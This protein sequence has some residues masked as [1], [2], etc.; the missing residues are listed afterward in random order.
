MYDTPKFSLAGDQAIVMA[1]GD[2]ISPEINRQV[3][4]MVQAIQNAKVPGV[5]EL[6]PTYRSLLIYY[7]PMKTSVA[8]LQDTL[9]KLSSDIENLQLR[10]PNV[11]QIPVLYGG[12]HGP[13]LEFVAKHAGVPEQEVIDVHSSATYLVYAMG[14]S[15]GF[16]Y[17]G[18]LP[19]ALSTPR[20]TSPRISIPAGSVGIA[21]NQTGIYPVA[22]PGG[23]QLIGR[24]PLNLFDPNFEPPTLL[25]AGDYVRFS[26][27]R[28]PQE[29]QDIAD[30]IKKGEYEVAI[31]QVE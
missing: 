19:E 2:G 3:H 13:D 10:R 16:P 17:L 11:V 14:F 12:E 29:Y 31:E 28:T 15:P 23:W 22:S 6:V 9:E 7:D 5:S 4:N 20:L 18:G 24:T 25:D 30:L 1:F 8:K 21:E 27:L 26:L